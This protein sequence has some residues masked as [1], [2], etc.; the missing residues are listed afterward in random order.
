MK[1]RLN[2]FVKHL[3]SIQWFSHAGERSSNARVVSS[4]QGGWDGEGKQMLAAWEPQSRALEA[5]AQRILGDELI[6]DVFSAVSDSIHE[7]VYNGIC[8]TLDRVYVDTANH[9]MQ[10]QRSADEAVFAEVMDSVKRD[11]CWAGIEFMIGSDGFF[12]RLL[13]LYREGR[14]PCSWDGEFPA[15]QPVVF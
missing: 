4:F 3:Q 9:E 6:D 11:V 1:D 15:G 5:K 13:E 7:P 12:G 8:S 10:L 14:W 2:T